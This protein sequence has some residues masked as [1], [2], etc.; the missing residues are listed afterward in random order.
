MLDSHGTTHEFTPHDTPQYNG[1]E[2]RAFRLLREKPNAM[3]Q[4]VIVAAS[5]RL[6]AEALN[7]ACEMSNMCVTS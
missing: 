4:E 6:W 2:E 5:D 1:M 3:L 7:Y